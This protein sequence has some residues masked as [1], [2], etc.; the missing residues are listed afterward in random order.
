MTP[1]P[2]VGE[3]GRP[4]VTWQILIAAEASQTWHGKIVT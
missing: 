1:I 3:Q 4:A 2:Q